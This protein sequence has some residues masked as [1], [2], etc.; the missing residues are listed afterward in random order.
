MDI[1]KVDGGNDNDRRRQHNGLV[2]LQISLQLTGRR[3]SRV[4]STAITSRSRNEHGPLV[5]AA[6]V[7]PGSQGPILLRHPLLLTVSS[8][9]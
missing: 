5:S 1:Q 8:H 3:G 9:F 4:L 2:E 7:Q 6:A